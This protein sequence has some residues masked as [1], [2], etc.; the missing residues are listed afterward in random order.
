VPAPSGAGP[1]KASDSQFMRA[2]AA[3]AAREPSPR[4]VSVFLIAVVVEAVFLLALGA[5]HQTRHILGIPGSLMALTAV[6]AG[7]TGGPLVGSFAAF[8]GAVIYYLTIASSG[9]R[10]ALLPTLVSAG[11]W[12]STALISAFLSA[13]LRQQ[14]KTHRETEVSLVEARAIQRAQDELARLH[15]AVELQLVPPVRIKD[16]DLEVITRYLPSEGRLR[17]G[18]DFVDVMSSPRKGLALIIGDV[19]GHGA[20]AAALG[21]TLRATWQGLVF[22]DADRATVRATLNATMIRERRDEDAFATACLAWIDRV[23]DWDRLHMLNIAH[24]PPLLVGHDVV[25]LEASPSLPMGV[26][27][28]AC[29]E[30]AIV[31]LTPPWS[32]VFYT[33]GLVEGLAGPES[34]D[35]FGEEAL[36]AWLRRADP[37]DEPAIDALLAHVEAANGGPLGDDVALVVVSRRD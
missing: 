9:T 17:L 34:R 32:L 10:G 19:S 5:V 36:V 3:L 11:I 27:D 2:V 18:G 37:I 30:P 22:S 21:A 14:A 23:G 1:L 7:A 20:A 15:E 35:R 33:D 4:P 6:I 12:I 31:T 24:P 29:W 16:L 8:A 13:A 25:R 26:G 28:E